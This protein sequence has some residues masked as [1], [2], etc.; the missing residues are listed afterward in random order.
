M[1]KISNLI[2]WFLISLL[3]FI[4][5]N[6]AIGSSQG[7]FDYFSDK[8]I[9]SSVSYQSFYPN[10]TINK[11][12]FIKLVTLA[13]GITKDEALSCVEDY[14]KRNW[15]FFYFQDV[16]KGKWYAP[17]VCIAKELEVITESGN[18]FYPA[19]DVTW[20]KG[21]KIILKTFHTGIYSD[22]MNSSEVM[23]YLNQPNKSPFDKM[24]RIET[25][26]LL[27][28]MMNPIEE[29]KEEQKKD[30]ETEQEQEEQKKEQE[31]EQEQEV[32]CEGDTE[33]EQRESNRKRI[34][35][36]HISGTGG[37][38][39]IMPTSSGGGG[40]GG[41]SIP[42]P[43]CICGNSIVETGENCDDGNSITESCTYGQTTC[44]VCGS[45]CQQT[46]GITSYCGDGTV[47]TLNGEE[48]DGG[49]DC[50]DQCTIIPFDPNPV[51][52][53]GNT[54]A[55]WAWDQ[56]GI[57][58]DSTTEQNNFITYL[59]VP[60]SNPDYKINRVF[61][62]SAGEMDFND[63]DDISKLQDFI[64]LADQNN[65]VIEYLTGDSNWVRTGQTQSAV[66]R[67]QRAI[68]FN[69]ATPSTDDD[70]KGIHFDIEPHTL[71]E[72]QQ[73]NGSGS[74]SFN[75][76]FQANFISIMQSCK[77]LIVDNEQNISLSADIPFWYVL[78]VGDLWNPLTD[79][80]SPMDFLTIMNYRDNETDFSGSVQYNLNGANAM[81]LIFGAETQDIS[82]SPEITFYEE[83]YLAMES[84]FASVK[85]LYQGNSAFR[86]FAIHY[87]GPYTSMIDAP[88]PP[89]PLSQ[90]LAIPEPEPTPEPEPE[91]TPEPE[92]EPTPEPS[93]EQKEDLLQKN[94]TQ[95]SL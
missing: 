13:S 75:D 66:D 62:G 19:S 27:Y 32:D 67:C 87:Y 35:D 65:I 7:S 46:I 36:Y 15:R 64:I 10:D 18:R 60:H 63:T 78:D 56:W 52:P 80:G 41:G 57:M 95:C 82:G 88:A 42:A 53:T 22:R 50:N 76:E 37:S 30:Q 40:G 54:R 26:D 91:P 70:L 71:A 11:A 43:T 61:L 55:V 23:E 44:G 48:C 5:S 73:N 34:V 9:V 58:E 8:N 17:Y 92:P 77:Q 68:D 90:S 84:V 33:C 51:M 2:K 25:L 12:E 93:T 47:D 79:S 72:W 69:L 28:S 14:Q 3:L 21:G 86:G 39:V 81:P 20:F 85:A 38:G 1:K 83:G 45:S 59:N 94:C 4:G 49:A 6:V 24:T 74:D 16:E 89:A 29:S 31:T